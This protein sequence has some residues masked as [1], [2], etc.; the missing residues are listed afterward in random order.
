MANNDEVPWES[1]CLTEAHKFSLRCV[2][3]RD[4]N[5]YGRPFLDEIIPTLMTELWDRGFNQSEIRSA[6]ER[7]LLE[8]P[9]YAAGENRRGDK[10]DHQG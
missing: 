3:L 6:F 4:S 10:A 1:R 9:L 2:E 8:L 7:A 5:P